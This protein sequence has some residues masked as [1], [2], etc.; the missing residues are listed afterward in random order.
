MAWERLRDVGGRAA[1]RFQVVMEAAG[2]RL[3]AFVEKNGKRMDEDVDFRAVPWEIAYLA[4]SG[5]Q[6]DMSYALS[7]FLK[8]TENL[9]PLF[10]EEGAKR[11]EVRWL[12][13][14]VCSTWT[15]L[16]ARGEE[17]I[18]RKACS[19][20]EEGEQAWTVIGN[21]ALNKAMSAMAQV[22]PRT[23]WQCWDKLRALCTDNAAVPDRVKEVKGS[24]IHVPVN[25]F[26]SFQI[27][28]KKSRQKEVLGEIRCMTEG[29]EKLVPAAD[30]TRYSLVIE[31]SSEDP[32][33][34][35]I[36][37]QCWSEDFP[38]SPSGK[39][40]AF[41]RLVEGGSVPASVR[42][43][44]RR[45]VL[46]EAL[47]RAL[48]AP[49][50]KAAGEVLKLTIDEYAFGRRKAVAEARRLIRQSIDAFSA[51]DGHFLFTDRGWRLA[52]VDKEREKLLFLVP[53]AALGPA[54]FERVTDEG[55]A[56]AVRESLLFERLHLLLSLASDAG[57]ELSF[58]D[59]P[60]ESVAWDFELDVSAGAIDWLEI[61]PEIRYKGR[62]IPR[63]V[64][65]QALARKGIIVRN[66]NLQILDEKS[67][68]ALS[69]LSR[70]WSETSGRQGAR[71][72]AS[73][74]R[75]RIIDLFLLKKEGVAVRLNAEDEA[76]MS[77]LTQFSHI[78]ERTIPSGLRADLRHYQ[79]EGFYWLA[80][81][82]EHGFGACLADDMGLGKTLQA[83]SLLAA[84][85]EGHVKR[86]ASRKGAF[87]GC[88]FLVVAPPSL[89]FNWEQEIKRFYPLLKVYL[90]QG[91]ERSLER[92][93]DDV[94]LTTYGLI[95]RDIGRLKEL[96][97]D[98]IVFD[99]AQAIK[100]IFADTTG[101]VRLLK[102][103]FKVALTGTP[104][105]NHVGE[106]FSIMD[107]VLP[108]LLGEYRA[109]W[110]KVREDLTTL[111]PLLKERTK[112]FMLRRTKDHILKELP[113]KVEHD[114]Y[115]DL[116]EDQKRF[117]NRTVQEVRATI[118]AAYRGKTA[119]Q[120]RIIALTAIMR[121]R[122]ICLT[123]RLLVSD[124]KGP[125]PKVEFLKD[126]LEELFSE[127]HSALVF[128]QFTSF[129]DM[130]ESELRGRGY[131]ILRLDGSTPVVKRKEIVETF[132]GSDSP[133]VFLLS[134][135]AGGQG[136]NL[137]RAT[138]VFHL[139]PWWNPA[140]ETQASD[141]SHRIGQTQKVHVTRLLMRHTVE[142]KMTALKHRKLALYRA[143]MD[144]PERSG[145]RAITREDFDFL[146]R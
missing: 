129:L 117:Y 9:Y 30:A 145:A 127:S 70:L 97:F 96:F 69:A 17:I 111:L 68:H 80:F 114:V 89:I 31:R 53:F 119:S 103:F 138:Y 23:G 45:P 54:L 82:Y 44:K 79:K 22:T 130:V 13:D 14:R 93:G 98:V 65:E 15:E 40:V 141:R 126:K 123:P 120:A 66:G 4:R 58:G 104:V 88:P 113:P 121:L 55:P 38:F 94:M 142:E 29:R 134:L 71:S 84:I 32:E 143:L 107:L 3:R 133:F 46:Y 57:I 18:V 144:V 10:Y 73:I 1:P 34:F 42:T 146:L 86:Q 135:K 36:R 52:S 11:H 115:L 20:W 49:S 48:D 131:P 50:R 124:L 125:S 92:E 25:V 35:L 60:V 137:T 139:D 74:P 118:E 76:L 27:A 140:V 105:E 2:S 72:V 63:E 136:L 26:R 7:V 112:P 91:K 47:F 95:R 5:Y 37:P 128:S 99:E 59:Y 61:R 110:G 56:M 75:L 28:F 62:A 43:R 102:G 78:E 77:R 106:Y 24:E 109:F 108:G 19:L 8:R 6:R 81:L 116:T 85:K 83:I 101:A 87:A 41:A 64:W 16:D 132:Q 122:Q 33:E 67:M 90:Y 100:N 12:G 51:E 21:F 39:V